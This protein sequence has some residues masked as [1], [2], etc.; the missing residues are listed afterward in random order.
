MPY[1]AQLPQPI[2]FTVQ[3]EALLVDNLELGELLDETSPLTINFRAERT[4]AVTVPG[5][6]IKA[7]GVLRGT[8]IITRD[9]IKAALQQGETTDNRL[10]AFTA[11]QR[12]AITK[13]LAALPNLKA[14]MESSL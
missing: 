2:P 9:E 13:I 8:V 5:I 4:A 7:D 12:A 10:Q 14:E 11:V 1:R 6:K 3:V